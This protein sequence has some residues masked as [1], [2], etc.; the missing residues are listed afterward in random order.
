MEHIPVISSVPCWNLG[1]R[2]SRMHTATGTLPRPEEP[3]GATQRRASLEIN[4][5]RVL[6]E[7]VRLKIGK[8]HKMRAVAQSNAPSGLVLRP[9]GHPCCACPDAAVDGPGPPR[10]RLRA[11]RPL[12]GPRRCLPGRPSLPPRPPA[13]CRR[14]AATPWHWEAPATPRAAMTIEG[15][16]CPEALPQ[17]APAPPPRPTSAPGWT[18][19]SSPSHRRRMRSAA[20]ASQPPSRPLPCAASSPPYLVCHLDSR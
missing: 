13:G 7:T 9:S 19:S 11:G 6:P 15:T 12:L 3:T 1:A 5:K 4:K 8:R 20:R 17:V 18:S 14:G 10:G 16:S 2:E